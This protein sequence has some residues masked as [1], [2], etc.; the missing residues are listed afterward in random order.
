MSIITDNAIPSRNV[1]PVYVFI[2]YTWEDITMEEMRR[3]ETGVNTYAVSEEKSSEYDLLRD[4]FSCL[5][6]CICG[7]N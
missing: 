1:Q 7:K 2:P 6:H 3:N 4:Y 5:A